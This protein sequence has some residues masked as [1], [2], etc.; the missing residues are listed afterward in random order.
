ME[1]V[2]EKQGWC[3]DLVGMK[4]RKRENVLELGNGGV[5]WDGENGVC[6]GWSFMKY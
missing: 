3:E 4:I 2:V 1:D 5:W 6:I